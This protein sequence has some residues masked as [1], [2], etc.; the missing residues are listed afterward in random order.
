M[1]KYVKGDLFTTKADVIVHGCNCLHTMGAGV[2]AIVKRDYP[3][4]YQAD[5]KFSKFGDPDK[6]GS[7]TK[8]SG[9]HVLYNNQIITIVNLYTQFFH[10]AALKPFD[11]TAFVKGF[12]KVLED[13]P[14]AAI[15]LPKIGAGLAG[16]DWK[17]IAA[18]INVLSDEK[19]ILVYEL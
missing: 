16:G 12:K 9:P 10:D 6:L 7:Y 4:A 19:E 14:D 15:A 11:Y 5:R 2:A 18:I 1:I 13:F 17:V 3:E 8:W